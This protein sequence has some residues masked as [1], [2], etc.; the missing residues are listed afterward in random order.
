M[1]QQVR[2]VAQS[3]GIFSNHSSNVTNKHYDTWKGRERVGLILTRGALVHKL[4]ALFNALELSPYSLLSL[5]LQSGLE[6]C[7]FWP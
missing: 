3:Y 1:K 4:N 2:S 7:V 6:S 5:R